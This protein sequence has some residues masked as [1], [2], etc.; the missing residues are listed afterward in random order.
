MK[1][2]HALI[3]ASGLFISQAAFADDGA[4]LLQKK[5]CTACHHATNKM[6]GPSLKAIADKYK[7]DAGAADKLAK[8]VRAGGGGSFG[9]M[10]MPPT[11][12]GVSDADIKAMV[13][14]IL[15]AK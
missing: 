4:A 8:K 11:P 3:L 5:S 6:V 13:A 15:A 9:T 7:S 14:A 1:I 10:S 12:A 2:Q